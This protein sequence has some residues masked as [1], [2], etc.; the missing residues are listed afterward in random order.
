[1]VEGL[2]VPEIFSIDLITVFDAILT[3][4]QSGQR[5]VVSGNGVSYM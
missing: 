1:M 3:G 2:Y 5:T 4:R